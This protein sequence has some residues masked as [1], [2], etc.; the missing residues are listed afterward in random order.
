M[1]KFPNGIDCPFSNNETVL[2]SKSTENFPSQ[3]MGIKMWL[4]VSTDGKH[5]GPNSTSLYRRILIRESEKIKKI[6]KN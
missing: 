2:V 1:R 6:G 4:K 3:S 5:L